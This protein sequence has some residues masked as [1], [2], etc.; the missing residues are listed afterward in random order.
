MA[1]LTD[2]QLE[3][4]R[5][6]ESYKNTIDAMVTAFCL[7]DANCVISREEFLS[8]FKAY[9]ITEGLTE[10][11]MGEWTVE[12]MDYL[13]RNLNSKVS[14]EKDFLITEYNNWIGHGNN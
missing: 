2:K 1:A 5:K 8:R 9:M 12:C 6:S 14:L 3:D 4:I 10:D 7:Y 13:S 11:E